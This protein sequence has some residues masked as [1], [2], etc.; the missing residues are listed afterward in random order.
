MAPTSVALP[1]RDEIRQILHQH[2]PE[3]EGRYGVVSLRLFGSY[4]RGEQ[5]PSSDVDLLV[6]IDNPQL[7][8]LQFVELRDFLSDLLGVSVDLV[9]KETLKPALGEQILHEA[10][11]V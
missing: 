2:L 5:Q 1:S 3:L 7:T 11:P 8:L 9:E 10:E 6:E 4:G